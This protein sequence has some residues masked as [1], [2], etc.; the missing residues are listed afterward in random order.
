MKGFFIIFNSRIGFGV[1]FAGSQEKYVEYDES[2]F[3]KLE[4]A[5]KVGYR[6][7]DT[8]Q[9]YGINSSGEKILAKLAKKNSNIF[10]ITKIAPENFS[11]YKFIEKAKESYNNFGESTI[12]LLILHWPSYD[13]SLD[14]TLD[15]VNHC[16]N[17]KIVNYFGISNFYLKDYEIFENIIIEDK[18]KVIQNEFSLFERFYC[19]ELISYCESK[20]K[21]FMNYSHLRRSDFNESNSIFIEELKKKYDISFHQIMLIYLL[22]KSDVTIPIPNSYQKKILKVILIH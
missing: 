12:D 3:S 20:N 11:Y 4:Y 19:E 17:N 1:G 2:H 15:A 13:T 7:F 8:A 21:Y 18:F 9:S 6:I 5:I 10:K 16:I 14:E 22:S